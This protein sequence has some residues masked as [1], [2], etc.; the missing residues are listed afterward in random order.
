L[1]KAKLVSRSETDPGLLHDRA[2]NISKETTM[3]MDR[4]YL[5]CRR[6][7]I[8][9]GKCLVLKTN[10]KQGGISDVCLE[11]NPSHFPGLTD[12]KNVLSAITDISSLRFTR[13]DF[14]SD[15]EVDF[16]STWKY[17]DVSH[18]VVRDRY[19]GDKATGLTFGC[20]SHIIKLYDKSAQSKLKHPLTR[21]E[22]MEKHKSISISG[23]NE[24]ENLLTY[25]PFSS[26]RF[27][28][29]KEPGLCGSPKTYDLIRSILET[30]G[31]AVGRKILGK[32]NNFSKT[33]E[34]YLEPLPLTALMKEKHFNSIEQFIRG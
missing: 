33:Y 31:L 4:H 5:Y 10:P 20:N 13:I 27:M 17:M 28:K 29:L 30:E 32:Q 6:Y 25:D 26:I 12:M 19:R 23:F 24:I 7:Q 14:C 1:D 21:I 22:V 15:L 34:R 8:A 16:G 2:R 3:V 11:L 9:K 18:K